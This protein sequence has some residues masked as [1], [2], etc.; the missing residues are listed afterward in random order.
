MARIRV[1]PVILRQA[2]Q[3]ASGIGATLSQVGGS[4]LG[5]AS[6]APSYD[7][8][9]GPRVQ[10]IGSEASARAQGF[11]TRM[12]DLSGQLQR[13]AQAFEA[14]DM[15]ASMAGLGNL[16]IGLKNWL[17]TS[18]LLTE[19][20]R[21][22]GAPYSSL[23]RYLLLGTLLRGMGV[24][25]PLGVLI[26]LAVRSGFITSF[27]KKSPTPPSPPPA[28]K[29]LQPIPEDGP[30]SQYIRKGLGGCTYYVAT[31]RNLDD[32]KRWPDAHEWD[33]AAKESGYEVND[34]PVEGAII[35]FE[36]GTKYK[37]EKKG[38]LI[39]TGTRYPV[40]GGYDDRGH[41][42][43]VEEVDTSYSGGLRIKVSE[44]I[45]VEKM[46]M[47]NAGKEN[48]NKWI[49]IPDESKTKISFIHERKR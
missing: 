38:N 36:K 31:R 10:A 30:T 25:L 18:R 27:G 41:V 47:G 9:F 37:Y 49:V 17:E 8:Q 2:S 15:S 26:S 46:G 28:E 44:G 34:K 40:E 14:A 39:D 21:S 29:S 12:N 6:S 22:A 42:A 23:L 35:V 45:Y 3:G 48:P 24:N 5:K 4:V 20:R 1:D 32:W 7:G 11:S 13:R 33:E 16:S 43:Y 19:W